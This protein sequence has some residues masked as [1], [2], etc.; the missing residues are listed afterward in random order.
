M[1]VK[2][3][4]RSHSYVLCAVYCT[5][6]SWLIT[7][8]I[9]WRRLTR[10]VCSL[11][12]GKTFCR[13]SKIATHAPSLSMCVC[14][15]ARACAWNTQCSLSSLET[16]PTMSLR[17]S[18][19]MYTYTHTKWTQHSFIFA[20]YLCVCVCMHVHIVSNR[21]CILCIYHPATSYA[22]QAIC[23]LS[24]DWLSGSRVYMCFLH[25]GMLPISISH[26]RRQFPF[27][28]LQTTWSA[29]IAL[30]LCVCVCVYIVVTDFH[31]IWNWWWWHACRRSS[32]W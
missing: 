31:P 5:T 23:P 16:W 12:R 30:V 14:V 7:Q 17:T 9:R 29:T 18:T 24:Y 3:P 4:K 25:S 15:C 6:S 26:T 27:F 21:V 10:Y 32:R 1:R 20:I 13:A 2:V 22:K 8:T 11:D 28:L 19:R